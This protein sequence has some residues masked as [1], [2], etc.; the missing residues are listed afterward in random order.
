MP[1][2][3]STSLATSP[4]TMAPT[5]AP[6]TAADVLARVTALVPT[7]RSRAAQTEQLR[8]MHPENLRELT[9]A[10]VFRLT[11]PADVGGYQG[12]D[13]VVSEVLTQIARGCP[14]TS[15]IAAIMV[16]M[17][18]VPAFLTDDDAAAE[19]YA[20][21]D[22]RMTGT[23]ATT[24]EAVPVEG[25][26]RVTGRW[27]WNTGGVHSNW[28][29]P[30]CL[31]ATENGP[32][33]IMV[34]VPV[35]DVTHEDSW[36]SAGMAGTATNTFALR[37]V[38]VPTGR[39]V[40]VADLARGV[41][42]GRRYADDPYFGR[43]WV[44]YDNAMAAGSMV[45]MAR[46]AMDVFMQT[47]P[48]RGAITY[49]GW[50][51]AAEAPLLHHQLAKAQFELEAAEMF[52]DKLRTLLRN[53]LAGGVPLDDRVRCRAWLGRASTHARACVNQLF[54][55][56]GA[57]QAL[58]TADLQRYFRDVNVLHQHALIQPNSSDELYG[59]MLAGLEPNTEVL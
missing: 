36:H 15:W 19:I 47:L 27:T 44:M 31:A 45:G 21:P 20:T 13:D 38:F 4:T 14:S 6:P 37:D 32:T 40:W 26:F 46:G 25:G 50:S 49:T 52:L 30:S 51:R 10:G 58:L 22:L 2:P 5:M 41:I 16:C 29:G 1:A 18:L 28:I 43:P 7:L 12:T 35:A 54:E 53:A 56:S 23:L 34:L 9:E 24:G 11:M 59:R 8:R 57:S 3:S 42:G 33:P 48:G 39:T 55:A 17:N